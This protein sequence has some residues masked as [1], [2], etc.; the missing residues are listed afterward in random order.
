M[1][2]TNRILRWLAFNFRSHLFEIDPACA[3]FLTP[4]LS[5]LLF[6]FNRGLRWLAFTLRI[7]IVPK[8]RFEPFNNLLLEHRRKLRFDLLFV[9]TT[10]R[11]ELFWLAL[12][13]GF[14]TSSKCLTLTLSIASSCCQHLCQ[15]VFILDARDDEF[16]STTRYKLRSYS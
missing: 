7:R 6:C 13:L 12:P 14:R 15:P 3:D 5:N 8:V 2:A 16:F 11:L 10:M 4:V 1:S 9:S